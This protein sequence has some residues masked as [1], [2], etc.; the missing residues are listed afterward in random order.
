MNIF[1][2][3]PNPIKC[4]EYHCDKHVVKMILET[5]QLLCSAHHLHPNGDYEPVYRLTHKNHPSAIWTRASLSQYKWLCELGLYLCFEYSKRYLK[6]HK[7]RSYLEELY[8]QL[9]DIDDYGIIQPPSCMPDS[10]KVEDTVQSY[11]NYYI[12]EKSY[13]AK[14]NYSETPQWY[15]EGLQKLTLQ[16]A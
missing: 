12:K 11:R 1:Y 5:T 15:T 8:I 9:P 3:D 6:T 2:L 4:A 10:C 13:M 16:S 14:W 7:C